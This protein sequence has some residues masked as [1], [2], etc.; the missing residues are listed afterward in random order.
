MVHQKRVLIALVMVCVAAPMLADA[1]N[2]RL[3]RITQHIANEYDAQPG[4]MD[5][6]NMTSVALQALNFVTV[7]NDISKNSPLGRKNKY[8]TKHAQSLQATVI[9]L[10]KLIQEAETIK[11]N[12]TKRETV[13]RAL[14]NVEMNLKQLEGEIAGIKKKQLLPLSAVQKDLINLL[15]LL[16][17]KNLMVAQRMI[18]NV[19][20]L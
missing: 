15:A 7:E 3:V 9:S 10:L 11:G 5:P 20:A 13:L 1:Y 12:K 14:W 18:R 16:A 19:E 6:E 4:F 2:D 8:I 17:A